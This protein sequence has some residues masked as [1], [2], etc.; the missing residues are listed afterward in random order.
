M[1]NV[2]RL[3]AVVLGIAV[4]AM[5]SSS[6]LRGDAPGGKAKTPPDTE[7][8]STAKVA[9]DDW[10]AAQTKLEKNP[11]LAY[12]PLK[13]DALFALQVMP[14]LPKAASRPRDIVIMVS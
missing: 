11:V 14:E 10:L 9:E 12:Q 7:E 6:F 2:R 4:T 1:T 8:L 3:M 5:I 13:G